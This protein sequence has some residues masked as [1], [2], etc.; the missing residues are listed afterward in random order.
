MEN[1][2]QKVAKNNNLAEGVTETEKK[3]RTYG[4]A[5]KEEVAIYKDCY[6]TLVRVGNKHPAECIATE[7]KMKKYVVEEVIKQLM[8]YFQEEKEKLGGA[9]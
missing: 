5:I 8:D 9:K 2:N 4:D 3:V 7:L 6:K 1:K